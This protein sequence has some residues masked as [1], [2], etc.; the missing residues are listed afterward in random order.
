M[1]EIGEALLPTVLTMCDYSAGRAA[2]LSPTFA[3]KGKPKWAVD[4]LQ[5]D[6][7]P[8]GRKFRR[9]EATRSIDIRQRWAL[10]S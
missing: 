7:D 9:A 5:F 10:C 6:R 4:R 8:L 1:S 3:L 2:R